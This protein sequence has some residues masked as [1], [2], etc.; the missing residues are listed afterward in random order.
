MYPCIIEN[1]PLLNPKLVSLLEIVCTN[2]TVK[3]TGQ[4]TFCV[5]NIIFIIISGKNLTSNKSRLDINHSIQD[6]TK[7]C[8]IILKIYNNCT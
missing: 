3:K 2:G 6:K 5:Q 1:S 4:N 8:S 7:I